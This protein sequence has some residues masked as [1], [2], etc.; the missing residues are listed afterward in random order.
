MANVPEQNLIRIYGV[1]LADINGRIR[2]YGHGRTKFKSDDNKGIDIFVDYVD[3]FI[4][5][6][7]SL[8]K[9][10]GKEKKFLEGLK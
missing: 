4:E 3:Y 2:A 5:D 10:Q 8:I 9:Q 6:L 1:T 7:I